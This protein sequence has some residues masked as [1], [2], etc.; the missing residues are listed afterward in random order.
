MRIKKRRKRKK[1][2]LDI[3]GIYIPVGDDTVRG[4]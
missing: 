1:I 2:L 4:C 3:K